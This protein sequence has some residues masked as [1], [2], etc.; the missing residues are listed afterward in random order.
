M[1]YLW[2]KYKTSIFLYQ[3]ILLYYKNIITCNIFTFIVQVQTKFYHLNITNQ[4][5]K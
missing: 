4:F 2:N 5:F 1:N 3:Q